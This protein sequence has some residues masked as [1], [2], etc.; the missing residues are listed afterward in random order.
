[1]R[2]RRRVDVDYPMRRSAAEPAGVRC[3]LRCRDGRPMPC[4]RA[5]RPSPDRHGARHDR[6]AALVP[7]PGNRRSRRRLLL[8]PRS[9]VRRARRRAV[10]RVRLRR[11]PR[12]EPDL[13][14]RLRRPHRPRRGRAHR[15]RPFGAVVPR[16]AH[17]VLHDP[18]PDDARPPGQRRRHAVPVGDLL[19]VA[20]A[21]RDRASRSSPSSRPR[22]SGR[23][24]SSPRSPTPR[25]ST[26]PSATTRNTSR[27]IPAQP[28][29]AAVVAPKVAKFRKHFT[30]RLKRKP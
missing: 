24:R 28:Y 8:V 25:R 19:P 27:A 9:R 16:S 6:L 12:P 5:R 15:L 18:R 4:R 1:M 2:P 20:G 13:R 29:C 30:E 10:G 17:R 7:C 11:R 22:S 21:A 3:K 23:I 14:G 26:R